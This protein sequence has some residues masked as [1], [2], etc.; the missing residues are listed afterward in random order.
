MHQ[1]LFLAYYVF[2]MDEL[3]LDNLLEREKGYDFCQIKAFHDDDQSFDAYYIRA[4]LFNP[5]QYL[6]NSEIQQHNLDLCLQGSQVY[7]DDFV[8]DF[9]SN[10]SFWGI[11]NKND[12]EDI[13]SGR[14]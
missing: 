6:S 9:K 10:T 4:H 3:S 8:S 7:G 1:M 2:E 11:N 5:Y 12:L 13:W 14:Y